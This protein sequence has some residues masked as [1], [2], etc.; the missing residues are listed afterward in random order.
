VHQAGQTHNR[1]NPHIPIPPL[2]EVIRMYEII[3]SGAGAFHDVPVVGIALN[4]RN[5]GEVEAKNAIAQIIAETGLP[6]TDPIRFGAG[7]LLD[8]VMQS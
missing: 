4:T 3:A 8:A 5:L 2:P 1:N 7:L 6:C